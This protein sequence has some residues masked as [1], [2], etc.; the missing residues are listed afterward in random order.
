MCRMTEPPTLFIQK[1]YL[2]P[3]FRG[4]S[5]TVEIDFNVLFLHYRTELTTS[6]LTPSNLQHGDND[7]YRHLNYHQTNHGGHWFEVLRP[8]AKS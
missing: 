8:D 5:E 6:S 4:I 7:G 3:E 2:Q 1:E